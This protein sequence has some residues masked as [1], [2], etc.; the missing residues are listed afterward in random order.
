MS[1]KRVEDREFGMVTKT[2]GSYR[3]HGALLTNNKELVRT[4]DRSQ[5][6]KAGTLVRVTRQS[7]LWSLGMPGECSVSCFWTRTEKKHLDTSWLGQLA[8][9]T[10]Q[11][12]PSFYHKYFTTLLD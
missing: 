7:L 12:S 10:H 11:T 2:E 6:S 1:V 4:G 5:S 3:S 9:V 8:H